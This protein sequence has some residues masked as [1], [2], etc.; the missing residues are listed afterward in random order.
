ML[1]SV[2]SAPHQLKH[3]I[4]AKNPVPSLPVQHV[5]MTIFTRYDSFVS[6]T[7]NSVGRNPKMQLDKN[8]NIMEH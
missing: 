1:S 7:A 8:T 2:F 4:T 3:F 6:P 5:A